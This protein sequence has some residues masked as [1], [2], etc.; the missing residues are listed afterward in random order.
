ML[1]K[2]STK[3]LLSLPLLANCSG[4]SS[5]G[6]RSS[7]LAN[8]VPVEVTESKSGDFSV[9]A[10]TKLAWSSRISV[11]LQFSEAPAYCAGLGNGWRLPTIGELQ[12]TLP[13]RKWREG[14][15][16]NAV[17]FSSEEIPRIDDE[18]QPLVLSIKNGKSFAGPGREGYAR[19]VHGPVSRQRKAIATLAPL[20]EERWWEQENACPAGSVA[21][22]SVGQ[23]VSCKAA[24]G[25]TN[26]RST[27]WTKSQRIDASYRNE[28]LHGL[29]V[30]W[31]ADGLKMSQVNYREGELHGHST[32]LHPNGEKLSESDYAYGK[33]DGADIKWRADGLKMSAVNYHGGVLHG[34]STHWHPNGEKSSESDYSNGKL[35]GKEVKWRANAQ[36]IS[37]ISYRKGELHGKATYWYESGEKSSESL[38][39]NGKRNGKTVKWRADGLEE[40]VISYRNGQLHGRSTA[41]FP[42]GEKSNESTYANGKRNGKTLKWRDNGQ[43][44]STATYRNGELH[45][46]STSYFPNG[47]R[48]SES[49]FA[50][51]LAFRM[52]RWDDKGNIV[53]RT[54]YENARI[55]EQLNYENGELRNGVVERNHANGVASYVGL[56][57]NGKAQGKHYGY[58]PNGKP[59]FERN[60]NA[61]GILSGRSM[62]WHSNGKTREVS[63]FVRGALHGERAFFD[64]DG[65]PGARFRYNQGVPVETQ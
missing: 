24:A 61:L 29:A 51:G 28:V 33:L 47:E 64:K 15:S 5:S 42:N 10:A 60:Y 52:Q 8:E 16:E 2:Y 11:E 41:Y 58:H 32:H 18:K 49:T 30:K 38:Y 43:R 54:A 63:R 22:G 37:D 4:A 65:K 14:L 31:R 26:G 27:S 6:P 35:D 20:M 53:E 39:A 55:T 48:S 23:K 12:T 19:C 44:L 62:D 9:D 17:L 59:R 36:A 34:R 40:S 13:Q 25:Q 1:K 46:T 45:G 56:F 50:N 3:I 21:R 7:L 57:K